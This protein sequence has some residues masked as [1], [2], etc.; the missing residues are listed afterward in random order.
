[1]SILFQSVIHEPVPPTLA[2]PDEISKDERFK[3]TTGIVHD[4]KHLGG[5]Y[6]NREPIY[7]KAPGHWKVNY[8]KDLH[9]K[10]SAL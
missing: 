1:M 4:T 8:V 2:H 5:I 7:K 10:A 9:E 3:T 6:G